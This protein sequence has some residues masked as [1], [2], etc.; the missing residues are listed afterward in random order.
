MIDCDMIW[1][2]EGKIYP[3]G[4]AR[5]IGFLRTATHGGYCTISNG[6]K[7]RKKVSFPKILFKRPRSPF[8][9][10]TPSHPKNPFHSFLTLLPITGALGPPTPLSA[11]PTY[12]PSSILRP[13]KAG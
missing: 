8:P 10:N 13:L 9:P 12:D 2:I 4:L 1:R 3:L 11:L 5:A 7:H 6:I